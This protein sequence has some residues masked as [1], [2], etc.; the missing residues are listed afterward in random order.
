[1]DVETTS[2]HPLSIHSVFKTLHI[3]YEDA[4]RGV[5]TWHEV[6]IAWL[7]IYKLAF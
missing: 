7:R 3:S 4:Y 1:M 2:K 5:G 6:M